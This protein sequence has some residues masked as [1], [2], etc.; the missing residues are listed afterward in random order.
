MP[1]YL[2]ATLCDDSR[3]P[4]GAASALSKSISSRDSA[5]T[6]MRPLPVSAQCAVKPRVRLL[7]PCHSVRPSGS[8][9][10]SVRLRIQRRTT[11]CGHVSAVFSVCLCSSAGCLNV[12]AVMHKHISCCA[13][14]S[15]SSVH[16]LSYHLPLLQPW[17]LILRATG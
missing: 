14:E 17:Y 16:W 7:R 12:T 8:T 1:G 6:I 3:A 13:T 5:T 11:E 10:F 4:S 9:G 15:F 2:E